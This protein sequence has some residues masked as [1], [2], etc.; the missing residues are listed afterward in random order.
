MSG[1]WLQQR[2]VAADKPVHALVPSSS[3]GSSYKV[4]ATATG[5]DC[6]CPGWKYHGR[7]KH[8]AHVRAQT[9]TW[10]LGQSPAQ[11]LA[12]NVAMVCPACGGPTELCGGWAQQ[13]GVAA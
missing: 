6:T 5:G 4:Y 10:Q 9:C 7:C 11:S 12:Q 8:M 2:C 3:T 13:E 1:L